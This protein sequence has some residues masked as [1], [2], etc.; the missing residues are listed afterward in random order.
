MRQPLYRTYEVRVTVDRN[1]NLPFSR[2]LNGTRR[3]EEDSFFFTDFHNACLLAA[4]YT[5]I[6]RLGAIK[7]EV[8]GESGRVL[9]RYT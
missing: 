1:A 4:T 6:G 5:P 2:N 9:R 7:G 8:I 3:I